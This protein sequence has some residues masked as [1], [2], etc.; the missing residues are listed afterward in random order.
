MRISLVQCFF[1]FLV[2][3]A[4]NSSSQSRRMADSKLSNDNKTIDSSV[5]L[6]KDNHQK[7]EQKLSDT[8]NMNINKEGLSIEVWESDTFDVESDNNY[9]VGDDDMFTA[10]DLHIYK[11]SGEKP[12]DVAGKLNDYN[13]TTA[14]RS[15]FVSDK[16]DTFILVV[17]FPG[18]AGRQKIDTNIVVDKIEIFNGNRKSPVDWKKG[19]AAKEIVVY[20]NTVVLGSLA[21]ENTYKKQT[22]NLLRTPL[23]NV[24]GATDTIK[25]VVTSIYPGAKNNTYYLSEVKLRGERRY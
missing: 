10:D 5:L 1:G 20:K 9:G 12:V 16:R 24:T 25:L 17:N 3:G 7:I 11:L 6:N 18:L 13:L 23:Y 21:L 2:L 15:S 8:L 14:L 4:C 19:G 22:I